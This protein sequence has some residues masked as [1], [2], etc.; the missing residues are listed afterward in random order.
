MNIKTVESIFKILY[1]ELKIQIKKPQNH[2]E[3]VTNALKKPIEQP[4]DIGL[5]M[6]VVMQNN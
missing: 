5:V 6:L 4:Q 2:L 1:P 3:L